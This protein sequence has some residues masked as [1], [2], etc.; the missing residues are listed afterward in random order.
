VL[1]STLEWIRIPQQYSAFVVGKSR[2]GRRG[3]II[4]TAAGVH[5]GFSGCVTLEI[6]NIGEVPVELIAGMS[7]C[8]LFFHPIQ[9]VLAATATSLAGQRKPRLGELRADPVLDRL[10]KTKG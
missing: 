10:V 9:G 2:L 1:G 8:Q 7:I 3:I 4:E 6:A 5:P